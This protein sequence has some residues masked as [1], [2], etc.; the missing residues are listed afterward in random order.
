MKRILIF[1]TFNLAIFLVSSPANAI[2]PENFSEYIEHYDVAME[3]NKNGNVEIT[4]TIVYNF[5]D[6]LKHGI[7]RDVKTVFVNLDGIKLETPLKLVSIT[8]ENGEEYKYTKSRYNDHIRLKIGD[9]DLNVTGLKTYVIKYQLT[10]VIES[11]SDH[12]EIFYNV[13]G[14]E[15]TVPIKEARFSA[16]LPIDKIQVI[17]SICFTGSFGS[18]ESNCAVADS[19]DVQSDLNIVSYNTTQ[20]LA[21]G[22]AFTV[23]VSFNKGLITIIPKEEY[24]LIPVWLQYILGVAAFFWYI[25]T[26]IFVIYYYFKTGRDPEPTYKSIPA[27][28]DPPTA[29]NGRKLTPAEVGTIVD[30]TVE[31]RDVTAT[32]VDLAIRGFIKIEEIKDSSIM[33]T[34]LAK[35][36]Y[37]LS[38]LPKNQEELLHFESYLLNKLIKDETVKL[39]S[40]KYTFFSDLEKTK[41]KIYAQVVAEK[42]FS[43]NPQKV[44]NMWYALTFAS[45]MTLNVLLSIVTLILSKHMPKKTK[46][47]ADAAVH[48]KGLKTFLTSQ[49]KQLEFQEENFYMFEKLLP[50]AVAFNVTSTWIERFKDLH[51]QY[52]PDWYTG[53]G[54]TGFSNFDRTMSDFSQSV[55]STVSATRS[56]S[57]SSSGFGGGG[58]SGGGSSGG[59]GGGSW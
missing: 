21:P 41:E 6:L 55:N 4:E 52:K 56:S 50:Y 33:G 40:L 14:T 36:D 13:I 53:T 23:G 57:G 17:E 31:T 2:E 8:N 34:L 58:S 37:K 30:E 45:F 59:G 16:T 35:T 20:P 3:V 54:Y 1:I 27:L 29:L 43:K 51:T 39:S 42:F 5:K 26:P 12:D 7:Y 44:R 48:A 38:K 28:F 32:L 10:G 22:E 25:V 49:D 24:H 9:A 19:I 46:L 11:F 47:G 18:S 15:W